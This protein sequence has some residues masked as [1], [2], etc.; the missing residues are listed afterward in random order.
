VVSC[1]LDLTG[2]EQGP[3]A[4]SCEHGNEPSVHDGRG[5]F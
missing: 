5:I 3:I 4:G 2:S 1:E